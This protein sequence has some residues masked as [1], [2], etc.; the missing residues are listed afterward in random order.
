[1]GRFHIQQRGAGALGGN[2]PGRNL[3]NSGR[4]QPDN[5]PLGRHRSVPAYSPEQIAAYLNQIVDSLHARGSAVILVKAWPGAPAGP[6]APAALTAV[7]NKADLFV[8]WWDGFFI[9]LGRPL[10]QYDAG[11]GEHLN[12]AATDIIVARAVPDMERTLI[13]LGFRPGS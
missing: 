2:G 1:M 7:G 11:D 5:R 13:A 8:S 6:G 4:D 12:D 10:P 9:A 3:A